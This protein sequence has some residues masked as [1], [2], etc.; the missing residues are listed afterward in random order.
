MAGVTSAPLTA[1]Y[2]MSKHAVMA[3]SET[4]YL[5]LESKEA[6]IG[7][8]V[9]CPEL[10]STGIGRSERNRPE[11][12]KRSEDGEH[13]EREFVEKV[14]EQ[15]ITSGLDPSVMADRVVDAIH[16]NRFYILSEEGG[17]WRE[18][19]NRRLEDIRLGRN[20]SAP[21]TGLN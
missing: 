12:L 3:L 20:P 2:Y 14:I 16:E 5:E 19:C 6:P 18:S 4:V 11:H 15:M 8:S 7:V 9:L 13:P 10:I 17:S 21:T 1:A